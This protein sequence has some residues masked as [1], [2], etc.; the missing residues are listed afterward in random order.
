MPPVVDSLAWSATWGP[1][2]GCQFPAFDQLPFRVFSRA[3]K[4]GK[5]ADF[6]SFLR[7]QQRTR[8][9]VRNMG[10]QH[11]ELDFRGGEGALGGEDDGEGYTRVDAA[12]KIVRP[13]GARGGR[14]RGRGGPFRGGGRDEP[15]AG[16]RGGGQGTSFNKRFNKLTRARYVSGDNWAGK[17]GGAGGAR[18][19]REM[20]V[21]IQP[22]W[23]QLETLDLAKVR[24]C[25]GRARPL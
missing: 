9:Y 10:E 1:P 25:V 16:G 13:G 24:V 5:V 7:F 20:S 2:P 6:G 17:P 21:K 11:S 14:G 12:S 22:D 19:M 23:L 4:I 15:G 18:P 3:T 8:G